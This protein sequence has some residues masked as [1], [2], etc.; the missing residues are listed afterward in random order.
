MA[1]RDF[2][3]KD[4]RKTILA[5]SDALNEELTELANA[6]CQVIQMEEPQIHLLAAKGLVDKVLNPDF[7]VEV[8]N[9]TVRA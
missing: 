6:G 3:Y 7:M 8:F 1:V 5:I 9:N 2:H 4:L